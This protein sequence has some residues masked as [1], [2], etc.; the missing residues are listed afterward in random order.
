MKFEGYIISK[1]MRSS[2]LIYVPP[3]QVLNSL[4]A[5]ATCVAVRVDLSIFRIQ[6]VD[7]GE[8]VPQR[9]L[10]YLGRR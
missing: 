1:E 4:D 9:D 3:C 2:P 8:G 10:K 5:G 7:N 6:V